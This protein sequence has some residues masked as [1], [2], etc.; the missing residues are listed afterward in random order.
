MTGKLITA[1]VNRARSLFREKTPVTVEDYE[2]EHLLIYHGLIG[3]SPD[4]QKA[5]RDVRSDIQSAVSSH[6]SIQLGVALKL[7]P[8]YWE[9]K[10]LQ[11]FGEFNDKERANAFVSL[12][13]ATDNTEW[14]NLYEPLGHPDWRVRA[15]AARILAFYQ[16]NDALSDLTKSLDD[17]ATSGKPAFAHIARAIGIIGGEQARIALTKHLSNSEPWFR[18]DVMAALANLPL[19]EIK[20]DFIKALLTISPLSDYIAVSVSRKMSPQ[21]LLHS[22]ERDVQKGACQIVIGLLEAA[23]QTFN[24]DLLSEFDFADFPGSVQNILSNDMNVASLRAASEITN[25]WKSLSA[26]DLEALELVDHKE[27]IDKVIAAFEKTLASE[28]ALTVIKKTLS[29]ENIQSLLQS[30]DS[31]EKKNDLRHAIKLAGQHRFDVSGPLLSILKQTTNLATPALDEDLIVALGQIGDEKASRP[32]VDLAK[33]VVNV[34]SRCA[35]IKSAQPVAEDEPERARLYWLIL[36]ALGNLNTAESRE[37]LINACMD[38][39]PD[40]REQALL[41]LTAL[42]SKF[43]TADVTSIIT[44]IEEGLH[45]PSPSVR[46]AAM[47]AV[48]DVPDPRFIEKILRLSDS[49]EVSVSRQAFKTLK[50]LHLK[51]RQDQSKNKDS[52][53]EE[54]LQI[55]IQSENAPFK[56]KKLNDFLQTLPRNGE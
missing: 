13:P 39:A 27:N 3:S 11:I 24:K 14:P 53:V 41:S 5:F 20:R 4:N 37:L 31:A 16:A 32:L 45:D 25:T 52:A 21:L 7:P 28:E 33:A 29:D 56:L 40:K 2:Q 49:I 44:I 26:D 51:E 42:H 6:S 10:L 34:S 30:T 23:R 48:A 36:K 43:S 54:A 47:A 12:L 9:D 1:L 15:N 17:T 46:I 18:V 19:A 22:E 55:K 35:A 8:L 50:K 38:F